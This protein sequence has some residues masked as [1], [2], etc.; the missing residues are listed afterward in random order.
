MLRIGMRITSILSTCSKISTVIHPL[1]IPVREKIYYIWFCTTESN[2]TL[3]NSTSISQTVA[4]FGGPMSVL[5]SV[6]FWGIFI[7][8][9]P[10]NKLL[11]LLWS[12]F[13][14]TSINDIW[15]IALPSFV[16]LWKPPCIRG[17]SGNALQKASPEHGFYEF[18]N[19]EISC[20]QMKMP[21]VS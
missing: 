18:L 13:S 21:M 6:S 3:K 20:W 11:N 10:N 12:I 1:H 15:D 7:Q 9:N 8:R 4:L 19:P 14:K 2:K 17:F 16:F 5:A